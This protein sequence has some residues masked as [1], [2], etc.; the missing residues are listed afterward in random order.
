MRSVAK[1]LCSN[2]AA[3]WI[4]KNTAPTVAASTNKAGVDGSTF[5]YIDARKQIYLPTYKW[6]LDHQLQE[7]VKDLHE[8]A[9]GLSD[10][11]HLYLKDYNTN[12]DVEKEKGAL[13]H[14]QLLRNYIFTGKVW[15]AVPAPP[16]P[17]QRQRK[18]KLS[19]QP[20]P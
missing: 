7:R 13:S 18:R 20:V 12:E 11:Q 1:S 8:T 3:R 14:A 16:P 17:Q 15:P 4:T 5:G 19:T 10:G 9:K 2:E 6:A